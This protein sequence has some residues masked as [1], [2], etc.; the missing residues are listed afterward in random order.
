M[1]SFKS[2]DIPRFSTVF[3][4]MEKRNKNVSE[5]MKCLF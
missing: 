5:S 1:E 4:N 3:S 2:Q